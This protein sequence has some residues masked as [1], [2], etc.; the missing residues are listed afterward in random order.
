M[1]GILRIKRGETYAEYAI[2]A[3]TDTPITRL[4]DDLNARIAIPV[5]W[6]CSC[7]QNLCGACAMV[8]NHV[9]RLACST[10]F[11]DTGPV[12]LLEPLS[13][14]PLIADLRVD[15]SCMYDSLKELK[16]WLQENE[17]AASDEFD[18]LYAASSCIMCGCC[19]E[20]CPN[21]TGT[22]T[23]CGAF[24]ANAASRMIMQTPDSRQQ[25]TIAKTAVPRTTAHCS[26]SLSCEV[27]CPAHIPLAATISRLNRRYLRQ[28]F[29]R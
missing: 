1:K 10:M 20:V 5:E 25:A 21:Y 2:E 6:E 12:V 27:I 23:F 9:P 3:E 29:H 14:F 26:K 11:G 13:K 18:L 22:D 8:I 16:L 17:T 4:L 19:L 28:M 24:A 7:D 15:R